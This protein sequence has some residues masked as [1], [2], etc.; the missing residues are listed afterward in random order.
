MKGPSFASL[1]EYRH[2]LAD[3]DLWG[4]YLAGVV[5]DTEAVAGWNPTFPTFV[6][7]EVVVKLF[8]FVDRWE[9]AY[10]AEREAA[11]LLATAPDL[12]VPRLL[13]TGEAGWPYLLMSR[14]PGVRSDEADLTDAEWL[15]LVHAVGTQVQ[16]L[17]A[18]PI[19][20]GLPWIDAG[21]LD[22]AA[23]AAHSSLPPYLAAQAEAYVARLPPV[24]PVVVHADL[25]AMHVFVDD[26][27]L[28]GI[29]D[30][31]E[32]SVADRHHELIQVYRDLCACDGDRFEAFLASADWPIADDFPLRAL[33]HA[34]VRQARGRR[35]DVFMPIAERFALDDIPTLDA[36]ATALFAP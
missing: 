27:R 28:A 29:I 12:A 9:S 24:D 31:G 35:I 16:R 19:P 22:I 17:H 23:G 1:E 13:G 11:E 14:M 6:C 7:G 10:V 34:L 33:G 3:L 20:G 4:P 36:L 32:L 8:G 26:R 18:L 15:D 21:E 5:G 25:C 2:H 30:W